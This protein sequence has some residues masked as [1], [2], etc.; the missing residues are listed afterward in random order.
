MTNST[1]TI[2]AA[3]ATIAS[4]ACVTEVQ[5]YLTYIARPKACILD[6]TDWAPIHRCNVANATAKAHIARLDDAENLAMLRGV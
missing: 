2:L 3:T 1:A 4:D 5:A 6:F